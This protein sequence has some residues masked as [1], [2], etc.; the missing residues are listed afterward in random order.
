LLKSITIG[1]IGATIERT[2]MRIHHKE[3]AKAVFSN[4][5][6]PISGAGSI[7][8][9]T[10]EERVPTMSILPVFLVACLPVGFLVAAA[11]SEWALDWRMKRAARLSAIKPDHTLGRVLVFDPTRRKSSPTSPPA[12]DSAAAERGRVIMLHHARRQRLKP[13]RARGLRASR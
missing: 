6:I 9:G 3:F 12:P 10:I 11:V 5:S 4:S 2:P 8:L 1:A 7:S 13:T